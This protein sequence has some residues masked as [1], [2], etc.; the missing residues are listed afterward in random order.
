[1]KSHP[2]RRAARMS[3]CDKL[4][5]AGVYIKNEAVIIIYDRSLCSC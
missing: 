5:Y 2:A 4:H 3:R 1:M